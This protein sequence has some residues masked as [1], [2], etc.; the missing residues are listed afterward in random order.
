MMD[1]I[2]AGKVDEAVATQQQ[3]AKAQAPAS[4]Q[5]QKEYGDII[6]GAGSTAPADRARQS[7]AHAA[8][9]GPARV[10]GFVAAACVPLH[11]SHG[12]VH[13]AVGIPP[14]G[15]D[16]AARRTCWRKKPS[17]YLRR[18]KARR[19]GSA[20]S[21]AVVYGYF[22]VQSK[23][24][25][26]I[27]YRPTTARGLSPTSAKEWLRFSFPRQSA[28]RQL[29]ISDFFR[30]SGQRRVRRARRATRDRRLQAT[31]AAEE[32]RK[33]DR[34]QDYLF[35]HG[36]GVE[37]AEALA[38]LWHKRMR[39]ELGFGSEDAPTSTTCSTRAIAA[40]ATASAIPPARI[41]KTGPRSSS[42]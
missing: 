16:A 22:P 17:R 37:S 29:C 41:L 11:Q 26:L 19:R 39:Q 35:L 9:L 21:A 24:R 31:E 42:C 8:V 33:A 32:L 1:Q 12:P 38:E 5:S 18:C 3:R 13:R 40:A 34:Y 25:R 14:E 27:V 4:E 2:S 15:P 23:G 30:S 20:D 6:S 28:R 10:D 7:R 36:F